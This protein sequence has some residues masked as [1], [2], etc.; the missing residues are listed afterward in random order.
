MATVSS[1]MGRQ[2]SSDGLLKPARAAALRGSRDG[3]EPE[4]FE[5]KERREAQRRQQWW[6]DGVDVVHACGGFFDHIPVPVTGAPSPDDIVSAAP[7]SFALDRLGVRVPTG[8][9]SRLDTLPPTS[10]PSP[11]FPT[12]AA[13]DHRRPHSRRWPR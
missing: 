7:V 2:R 8:R 4:G 1:G 3:G 12:S 9:E 11:S 6:R 10:S 5:E 13:V